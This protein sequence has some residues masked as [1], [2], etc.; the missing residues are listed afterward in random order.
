[1]I[2]LTI[3]NKKIRIQRT[4]KQIMD[5]QSVWVCSCGYIVPKKGTELSGYSSGSKGFH[6]HCPRCGKVVAQF[7]DSK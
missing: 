1:M 2:M 7:I 6:V 3:Y 4:V 5:R